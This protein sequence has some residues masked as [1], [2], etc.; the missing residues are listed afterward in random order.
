MDGG[1]QT[2]ALSPAGPAAAS[3]AALTWILIGVAAV[4]YVAVI[5]LFVR[6]V[7]HRRRRDVAP[8]APRTDRLATAG[9]V[10]GGVVVPLIVTTALLVFT[11][12]ALADLLPAARSGDLAVEVS[13]RQYW[14]EIRYVDGRGGEPVVTANELHVPVGRRVRVTLF[15][16]DVI[17]S[18]WVPP[19]H[20]K[21]DAIPGITN[22]TWL[23]ADRPGTYRGQCAEYCGL[24]HAHMAV[25][26]VAQRPEDFAAW[27]EQQRRPADPP[28]DD[29]ARRG[30]R[31]FVDRGCA[32]CHRVRGT[33]AAFGLHGPDLTHLLSRRTLAAGLLDNS[34]GTRA[35]WVANSQMLKPG[36]LMPHVPLA[37]DEFHAILH[38]LDGLR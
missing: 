23:Q 36:N 19:L 14:W 24:M 31:L 9:V 13:A 26:V 21:I 37:A 35:G 3:I 17:H 12:H 28:A 2:S 34:K 29:Q 8:G 15:S 5:A 27:L 10:V 25:L 20:G 6:A 11:L 7:T 33:I 18:F 30:E 16:H 1:F 32:S 4:V 22:V 38:F